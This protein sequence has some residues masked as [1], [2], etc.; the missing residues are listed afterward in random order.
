[1]KRK[2]NSSSLNCSSSSSS[3]Q[4]TSTYAASLNYFKMLKNRR[5]QLENTTRGVDMQKRLETYPITIVEFCLDM[6]LFKEEDNVSLNSVNDIS[7]IYEQTWYNFIYNSAHICSS[8][9]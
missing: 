5:S 1:M 8:A 2:R 3:S 4:Q 7:P 6:K 9:A